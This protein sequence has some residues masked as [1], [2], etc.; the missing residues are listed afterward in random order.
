MDT[1]TTPSGIPYLAYL[2][3]LNLG[4]GGT[5]GVTDPSLSGQTA[6]GAGGPLKGA[7]GGFGNL[8]QGS[9]GYYQAGGAQSGQQQ[10]GGASTGIAGQTGGT[11]DPM[12]VLRQ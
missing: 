11:L 7:M 12:A 2:S 10:Q 6:G 1:T 3:G 4:Q 8:G 5:S 9:G